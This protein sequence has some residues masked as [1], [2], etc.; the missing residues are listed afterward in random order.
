VDECSNNS[1]VAM[2]ICGDNSRCINTNGS[3]YCNCED[4]FKLPKNP[5][6]FTVDQPGR[7]RDINECRTFPGI[8]GPNAFCSNTISNFTC[9]CEQ[10]FVSSTGLTVFHPSHNVTC[11]DVCE[12]D[13]TI[14]GN[15]TCHQE[16][17][18]HHCKCSAGFTNYGK[19]TSRCTEVDCGVFKDVNNQ[20]KKFHVVEDHVKHLSESCRKLKE[21]KDP[22]ELNGE[23]LLKSLLTIIDQV[24][25][26]GFLNDNRKVST[27]LDLVEQTL[28][29]IGPF[30]KK[31]GT[32]IST[33]HAEMEMLVDTGSAI[34]KG[35]KT[36]SSKQAK[37]DIKMEEAAGNPS[38][39]PGFT[40]VSLL[41]YSNLE[42]S[43]GFFSGM[44][45]TEN[46]S[47]KMNSKVVTVSVS[48]RDTKHLK[49]PVNITLF[50]L[51][52]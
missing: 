50:H 25:S 22:T 37:L 46:Q 15:G 11:T 12:I 14:C 31:P 16:A 6:N 45:K 4:G 24:L 32:K 47:F 9:T 41:S 38:S 35:L 21:S 48:N 3:Y 42:E 44:E 29:L 33:S 30:I 27:F 40:I 1:G 7:C 20:I 10:G 39:Y 5:G 8:C 28:K 43:A 23:G 17:S 26:T 36:L 18:G 49:E 52:Q 34:P 2:E 13:E 51:D 19:K